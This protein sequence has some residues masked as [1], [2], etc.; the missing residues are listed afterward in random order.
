MTEGSARELAPLTTPDGRT[1]T[2]CEAG[3]ADGRPA[4]YLHGT[5][6]SRLE[7]ALYSGAFA[8]VGL[9]LIAWDRPGSGGSTTQ[10]GR[11]LLD[12]AADARLVRQSLDLTER[13]VALGLSGGG[14]H[15][16]A[17]AATAGDVISAAIAINPGGPSDEAMLKGVP[18][19]V[20]FMVRAARDKPARW[21]RLGRQVENRDRGA[22][23]TWLANRLLDS[24]DRRVMALPEVAGPF[25][26]A[27]SE[28]SRQ[29]RAYTREA[30]ML[31]AQPWGLDLAKPQVP[32]H[33]FAGD[34]DPF[35]AFA[36]HLADTAGATVHTFP[37]GHVS[38][39][40]PEVLTRIAQLAVSLD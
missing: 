33:V 27:I 6:S 37:G 21:D 40:A 24:E 17:L 22:V 2:V 15:V 25:E 34:R 11:Q 3:A 35:R 28:G 36:Q 4:F 9:R 16:L 18:R 29:P 8:A 12:V 1:L 10:P 39:L 38:A 30:R 26:R 14:S 31:W 23:A 13:P 32:V 19:T 20:A 5:G 7:A